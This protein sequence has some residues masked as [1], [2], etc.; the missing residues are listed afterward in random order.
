MADF[1]RNINERILF[2]TIRA[3]ISRL[4][5]L[6]TNVPH[7]SPSALAVQLFEIVDSV[8]DSLATLE[9]E[10]RANT[11]RSN[12]PIRT[13]TKRPRQDGSIN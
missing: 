3:D 6:A 5:H 2:A 11:S 8:T 10:P 12:I 7:I 13:G 1:Y 4:H 9:N